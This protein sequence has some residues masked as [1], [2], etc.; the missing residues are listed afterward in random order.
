MSSSIHNDLFRWNLYRYL[1][2]LVDSVSYISCHTLASFLTQTYGLASRQEFI[3]PGEHAYIEL[4]STASESES[5]VDYRSSEEPFYP[6]VFEAVCDAIDP[7]PGEIYLVGAGILGKIFC[8]I[9]KERGGIA[10]DI[11][12]MADY[13]LG[14]ETRRYIREQF[15][16]DPSS[17]FI[18]SMPLKKLIATSR[19]GQND[20][21]T[22]LRSRYLWPQSR[23][24]CT[25]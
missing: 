20:V 10:L 13:W 2:N 25:V 3:I 6:I 18:E 23:A 1:F 8:N 12:S 21:I 15:I 14:H 4:F 11:G 5:L 24:G 19:Q 9:I 7:L 17:S 22:L 16:F